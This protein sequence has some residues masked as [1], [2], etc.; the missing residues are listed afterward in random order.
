MP[1][2]L[3]IGSINIDYTYQMPRFVKA[4]ETLS[5]SSLQ[6]FPGG[7]GFNQSVAFALAGGNI[8]HAGIVGR[9]GEYL[10]KHLKDAGV[11]TCLVRVS[12]HPTGHSII[13]V[14]PEGEN[15]IILYPGANYRLDE[16]FIDSVLAPFGNNDILV[17]QNEVSCCSYAIK[18]AKD[19][20]MIIFFNPSPFGSEIFDYPLD[21]IDWWLLNEVEGGILTG[22]D[23]PHTILDALCVI[24]PTS[25]A[26]LTLGKKGSICRYNGNL[27]SHESFQVNIL[28]T[29]AAGDTFTGYFINALAN[30]DTVKDALR[31]ASAAA[32]ISVSRPGAAVSIPRRDEVIDTFLKGH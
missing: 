29:T 26:V 9:D 12:D 14:T 7:K 20:G 27:Y 19:K 2:V 4:G 16:P 23:T 11:D 31:I 8:T 5:S 28:D 32:S 6:V 18:S 10:I 13:Q 17:L 3:N 15:S 21:L 1:R 24:Y 25:N 22:K 30:G